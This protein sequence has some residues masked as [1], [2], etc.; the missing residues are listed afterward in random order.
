MTQFTIGQPGTGKPLVADA[1]NVPVD[2]DDLVLSTMHLSILLIDSGKI[3]EARVVLA[4]M[5]STISVIREEELK[6]HSRAL[7]QHGAK[8]AL[9][10]V[11]KTEAAS[12][13]SE[14]E[15][16]GNSIPS[17]STSNPVNG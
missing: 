3:A 13:S 8:S 5:A 7:I 15:P 16:N 2:L 9:Q 12:N 17:E 10:K 14:N 11:A 6:A 1:A 4:H